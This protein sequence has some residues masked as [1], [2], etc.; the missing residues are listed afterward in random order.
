MW[1]VELAVMAL[2]VVCCTYFFTSLNN[3]KE[4]R[5]LPPGS[6]GFPF[7]GE[8]IQLVIPSYSLDLH[9]FIK[10][11]IQRYGPIFRTKIWG[12][13]IVMS[14]D[15]DFNNYIVQQEGKSVGM[16]IGPLSIF[17]SA[18][19][20]VAET[21]GSEY[22]H[23]YL[24][25]MTLSQFGAESIRQKLLP[26]LEE[27]IGEVLNSWSN[28]E[29][30]ELKQANSVMSFQLFAKHLFGYD[31]EKLPEANRITDNLFSTFT[32]GKLLLPFN[33]PGTKYH[34]FLKEAKRLFKTI[35]NTVKERRT[36]TE[37]YHGDFLDEAISDIGTNTIFTEDTVTSFALGLTFASA[38]SISSLMTL[39]FKFLS[40][41]PSVMEEL[42]VISEALRFS[43]LLPALFRIALKDIQIKGYTIP[44]GWIIMAVNPALHMNSTIFDD[45]LTFNP[46]RWKD[47]DSNTVSKFFRP[48]GMGIRQCPGA[49]LT[50][51]FTSTFLHVLV[52]KYRWEKIRGGEVVRTPILAFRDDFHIKVW[53]KGN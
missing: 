11:R 37:L 49:E 47:L 25:N 13:A 53:K 20:N 41:Y 27:K 50:R 2:L 1:I 29:S 38:V 36:S 22:L 44:A 26:Q 24:R 35:K 8:T 33:I 45:P 46:W 42:T 16:W 18:G 52:T 9:P 5:L 15:P 48:F 4:P 17:I 23:K 30:V 51:A 28:K 19:N 40:E 32:D 31:A 14:A 39:M 43:V 10:K 3:P 21:M 34:E 7:I 6:M 12:R